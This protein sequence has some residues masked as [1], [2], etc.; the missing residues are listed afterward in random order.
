MQER[1][2]S[3]KSLNSDSYEPSQLVGLDS[4]GK[5]LLSKSLGLCKNPG[6]LDPLLAKIE[7]N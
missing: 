6:S 1:K 7:N 4:Q 2:I 3:L 5:S